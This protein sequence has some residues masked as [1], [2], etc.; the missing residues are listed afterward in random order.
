[1]KLKTLR[2]KVSKLHLDYHSRILNDIEYSNIGQL[3]YFRPIS[4][5]KTNNNPNSY[6]SKIHSIKNTQKKLNIRQSLFNNSDT[7]TYSVDKNSVIDW[8]KQD[9]PD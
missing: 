4:K 9:D 2:D 1:M 7:V 5:S 3:K 8:K 6:S